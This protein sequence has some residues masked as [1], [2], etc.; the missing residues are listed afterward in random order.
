MMQHRKK[1]LDVFIFL[2]LKKNEMIGV[3]I[4]LIT[5]IQIVIITALILFVF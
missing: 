1:N 2:L 3:V 4:V 5:L